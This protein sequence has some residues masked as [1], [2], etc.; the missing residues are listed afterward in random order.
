MFDVE[1][2]MPKMAPIRVRCG[3]VSMQ[4]QLA[5]SWGWWVEMLS[6]EGRSRAQEWKDA[7][8]RKIWGTAP[9][10]QCRKNWWISA[11]GFHLDSQSFFSLVPWL[12]QIVKQK[13]HQL[14]MWTLLWN[15]D[16]VEIADYKHAYITALCFTTY[17]CKTNYKAIDS[18][19]SKKYMWGRKI[20]HKN[21]FSALEI[22]WVPSK[23]IF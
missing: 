18:K 14:Q 4:L 8:G 5:R 22:G 2:S 15:T 7:D 20:K 1:I 10:W 23:T 3:I 19:Y 12:H 6:L 16:K 21:Y 17:A 11:F 13:S 9:I